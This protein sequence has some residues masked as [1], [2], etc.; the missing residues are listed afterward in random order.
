VREAYALIQGRFHFILDVSTLSPKES[1]CHQEKREDKEARC[2]LWERRV[3]K[4]EGVGSPHSKK[5]SDWVRN[6]R[7]KL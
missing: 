2:E 5:R 4:E 7:F 3:V 1:V 6:G